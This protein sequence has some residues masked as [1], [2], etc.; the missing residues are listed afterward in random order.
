MKVIDR[1]RKLPVHSGK[2]YRRGGTPE[3]ITIHHSATAAG[4]AERFADYHVHTLGWPGIGYHYVIGKN[5]TIEKCWDE[6]VI[7]YHTAGF[8]SGNIGICLTGNGSFSRSQLKSLVEL[9]TH[10]KKKYHIPVS[11]IKGHREWSGQ[12]TECPG[13][14]S[15]WFREKLRFLETEPLLKAGMKG[16]AVRKLQKKLESTG[17]QLKRFGADGVY[18]KETRQAVMNYQRKRGLMV[19]GITGPETWRTLLKDTGKG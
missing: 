18:G 12:R 7:T 5:G 13:M 8:N 3:K 9:T 17:M 1:R 6:N 10:L 15:E 19:D 14:D 4:S 2:Q 16:P 11:R